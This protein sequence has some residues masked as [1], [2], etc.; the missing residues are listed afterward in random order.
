MTADF[1]ERVRHRLAGESRGTD[2][3]AV[4]EA[5][6]EEAGGALSHDAVLAAVRQ[7]RDEFLGAGPLAPLLDNESVTDVLVTAPD[8]V[9]TDGPEGLSR[10]P[11]RFADEDAVRRLAQRLALAAGRRL[12]DAQPYVDGWLP[13][14]QG[15]VRVHAVLPPIAANGTCLSLR[16]LRPATHDLAT[17]R[18]R[19]AFDDAGAEILRTVIS[20]RLAFLVTGGTGAGKTTLLSALLGTVPPAERIV[21]VEDAGELRP[22]HPQFVSLV[23]RPANVE[24]AGAVELPE[25]VREA[26]RM[27]PD[28]LIVGEVRGAEVCSLLNALNTGHEGG[29]CTLHANSP[30]EVP[31]RME[32]LAALGGLPRDAL[33]SQLSAAVR[34]I[35]HMRRTPTGRHLAEVAVLQRYHGEVRTHP[36]W[37]DG[38]WTTRRSLFTDLTRDGA[39]K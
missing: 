5:V 13:A 30:S 29:A 36:V 2:P 19:G 6:R 34:V 16:V 28:R 20:H 31:A 8:Q 22:S 12:D 23:A 37:R 39:P 10:T 26:L 25:L 33:H 35:L 14:Q 27:R 24:G 21:C 4:V 18:D 32:A 9:W 11:V 15:R 17:L 38:H 1:V 3:I 7:A